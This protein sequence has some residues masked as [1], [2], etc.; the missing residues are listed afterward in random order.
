MARI[1]QL[2]VLLAIGTT[3][4]AT[5]ADARH[6]PNTRDNNLSLNSFNQPVVQRSLYAL[7]LESRGPT[8]SVAER[9]RLRAWLDSLG[10][11][12]GDR[13]FV[14]SAYRSDPARGD[15]ARVTA[16]YGIL[17]DD[18][19][20]VTAGAVPPGT[21][22]VIVSRS[23]ASVPGCPFADEHQGPSATSKNY[24]CAVNSNFAAMIADP[25]DL[26]LG[27]VGSAAGDPATA[28]KAVRTYRDAKPTGS[29]GLMSAT[30]RGSAQ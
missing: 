22:R 2:A 28:A 23:V 1:T 10:I 25:N 27:E 20:P 18:G 14:D 5:A 24:G 4:G 30:T 13:I 16:E 7:D 29:N 17:L 26:V 9:G 12:Y 8:L 15:V 21:L 3:L 11:G 19:A 6:R